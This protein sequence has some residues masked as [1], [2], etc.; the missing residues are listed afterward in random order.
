MLVVL[1]TMLLVNGKLKDMNKTTNI[2]TNETELKNEIE[3][4]KGRY[5]RALADY[6]NL[7]KRNKVI[8]EEETKFAAKNVILKLLLIL[9]ILEKVDKTLNDQGVKLA[10]KMFYKLLEEEKITKINVLG[11]KFDPIVMECIEVIGNGKD[12]LVS[13]EIRAGYL[14]HDQ[15]LRVAQVKVGK[16]EENAKQVTDNKK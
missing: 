11:K 13:E 2:S 3:I 1:L 15:I 9:D 5:L 4:W 14:M 7:E 8:R 6:Q 10:V 16:M 12:D